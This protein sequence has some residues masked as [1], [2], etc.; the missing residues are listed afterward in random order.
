MKSRTAHRPTIA[1]NMRWLSLATTAA[2]LLAGRAEA[3]TL[4]I[5]CATGCAG[6]PGFVT[7]G[8]AS[9]VQTGA[10]LTVTQTTNTA[11]LNW[12]SFN[13]SADGTVTFV[14]PGASSI[15]L[16]KIFQADPAKI[17]GSLNANGQIYLISQNG[18]IFGSTAKVSV[19]GLLASTLNLAADIQSGLTAPAKNEQPALVPFTDAN[20][21]PL[22]SGAVAVQPGASIQTANAGSVLMFAPQITNEGTIQAPGGQV[23]LAAGSPVY[24]TSSDDPNIR[25][26]LVEVGS[27]GTV[28]N[29]NAGN[30]TITSPQ[31]LVGQIVAEH[32]NVT[33]AGLAVNQLGRVSATTTVN[34]NGSIRLQARTGTLAASSA[35]QGEAGGNLTLGPDSVTD[36]TLETSDPTTTVDSVP[37]AHSAVEMYGTNVQI[38]NNSRVTATSG[39]IAVQASANQSQAPGETLQPDGSRIY[40][41]PEATLD[42]SGATVELPASANVISAQLRG[43]EFA[44]FPLQRNG[45]LRG[46]TVYIDVRQ[47]GTRAD[48][49]TWQGTP[50]ADVSGEI[51][52]IQRN[53]A[54]RN[55]TGGTVSLQ[56][57]G[58]VILAPNATVNIAGGAINYDAGYINTT[59][60]VTAAGTLV[61]IANADPNQ[62]YTGIATTATVSHPKWG[63]TTTFPDAAGSP[64]TT[65]QPAYTEGKDAGTLNLTAAQFIFD[66]LLD[67][68]VTRGIYQRLPTV[69]GPLPA[70][71][72][73]RP[74][75]QVP[76]AGTL[77]IG[78]DFR[79]SGELQ[80]LLGDVSIDSQTVLPGL[81]AAGFDPTRDEPLPDSYSASILRP[82]LIG[83]QGIGNLQ[84]VS[85]G[86][87]TLPAS[88]RLSFSAD[89]SLAIDAESIDLLGS[90]DVSSGT[91][92][93]VAEQTLVAQNRNLTVSLPELTVGPGSELTARGAWVN[94]SVAL[95]LN[96]PTDPLLT[97]GGSVSLTASGGNLTVAA[98]SLI[99]VSGGAQLTSAGKL[100]P[101]SGGSITLAATPTV[102]LGTASPTTL[103]V[104][105]TLRAYAVGN[106]GTLSL[107]A[108]SVCIAQSDCTAGDRSVLWLTPDRFTAGGFA[109]YNISSSLGGIT[110]AP[111][112]TLDLYQQNLLAASNL[113]N[114]AGNANF[115][116]LATV[117]RLP[118]TV[119]KPSSL[120]LSANIFSA[121]TA[122]MTAA[123]V[124]QAPNLDIGAGATIAADARATVNLSS[125]T[126]LIVDGTIDAPAGAIGL[127]L[128]GSLAEIEF[129]PAQAIWLGSHGT[130]DAAGIAQIV[131]N[132]VGLRSGTVQSG[133]S[134]T[135][136]ANRGYF[137]MLPGSVM[138][139]AGAA[140]TIDT[141]AYVGG[142]FTT[143][144]TPVASAGGVIA[145][146][147]AEGMMLGGTFSAAP[148]AGA[149]RTPAGGS[150]AIALNGIGR[151]DPGTPDGLN[152]AF[153]TGPRTIDIEQTPTPIVVSP[154][155]AVPPAAS[156]EALVFADALNAAGFDTISLQAKSLPITTAGA[157]SLVP[158]EILFGQNATLHTGEEIE[159]D[160]ASV[161]VRPGATATL[162]APYVLMGNSDDGTGAP[163]PAATDGTGTLNVGTRQSNAEY[164]DLFGN[165]SLQGVGQANFYSSGDIRLRG[166][167]QD[168]SV[169]QVSAQSQCVTG[170]LAAGGNIALTAAQVYPDTLSQFAISSSATDGVID[171]EKSAGQ[172]GSVWSAG[173]TL[174]LSAA[175]I[176]QGGVLRAP[177]G[178]IVLE[179]PAGGA[180][181]LIDLAPGSLTSTSAAGMTI[182]FGTTEGGFDWTFPLS[183]GETVVYGTDGI[184][185]PAQHIAL[186]GANVTVASGATIDISGGGDLLAYEFVPG[187]GGTVDVLSAAARP[188]QYAIVPSLNSTVAPY[189]PNISSG[190]SLA[191]GASVYLAG[192]PGLP[193]GTYTLLPARYAM[194]PG[195]FLVTQVAGYTGIAPGLQYQNPGGGTVVAGYFTIAGTSIASSQ[196]SGFAVVPASV[197]SQ[198]AT[199]TTSVANQYFTDQ[200]KAAGTAATRLPMDSGVLAIIANTA[201]AQTNAQ[202]V[203]N[204]QLQGKPETGG[205]GAAV[206]ISS[207]SIEVVPDSSTTATPGALA[208]SATSLS[209]L[210]AQ[211]LLLGGQRSGAGSIETDAS[212]VVIASGASLSGPELLLAAT[213]NVTVSSGAVLTASGAAPLASKYKL[214]GDGTFLSV[215]ASPV[216]TVTR[217]NATAGTGVLDLQQGSQIN[218]AGGS[219]YLD[220]GNVLVNGSLGLSGGD[221]ALQSS[222]ISFGS[223]PAGTSG[224]L[225]GT[226]VLSAVALRGL[227]LFSRSTIDF[228]GSVTANT[229][230]LTLDSGGLVGHGGDSDVAALNVSGTLQ[231]SNLQGTLAS[232]VSGG[233]GALQLNA[234]D[235]KLASG[236]VPVS[237]F[238][239]VSLNAAGQISASAD[240]TMST[241]GDLT[242]SATRLTTQPAVT[243]GFTAAGKLA[244]TAPSSGATLSPVTDLGGQIQLTGQSVDIGTAIDLPAGKVSISSTGG[245]SG[246]DVVLDPGASINVAGMTRVYDG[247]NVAAPGGSISIGSAGNVLLARGSSVDLSGATGGAAGSLTIAATTGKVD[248]NGGLKGAGGGGKG[249]S[250]SVDAM[251]IG[252]ADSTSGFVA[253]NTAL[254]SDGFT[255]DRSVR[256]RGVGDLN[257]DTITGTSVQLVADQGNVSVAGPIDVSGSS[258]GSVLLAAS[259]DVTLSGNIDAHATGAGQTGGRVELMTSTGGVYFKPGAAINVAGGPADSSGEVG[260]GGTV[261]ARVPQDTVLAAAAASGGTGVVWQG[262]V[263]GAQTTTLEAFR[264]YNVDGA[265]SQSD[266]AV[267]QMFT[268]AQT[269]MSN[270]GTLL[271]NLRLPSGSSLV[272][273]PGIEIDDTDTSSPLTISSNWNLFNWRF[274]MAQDPNTGAIIPG[275]G[276][277]GILTLRAAAGIELD[278]A[279]LS[280]GFTLAS[281]TGLNAARAYTLPPTN[282]DSWSYRL[283]GGADTGSADVLAVNASAPAN[284]SL[285]NSTVRTGNGFIDVATSG[286]LVLGDQKSVI[287]TA[288][289]AGPGIPLTGN[290]L[291]G[292]LKGLAYP[293]DGGDIRITAAGDIVG[294][295]TNQFV[296]PWLW[297]VGGGSRNSAAAWTVSF[298]NFQQ[299]VAALGGGNVTVNAG[300]DITDLSVSAPSIGRQVGGTSLADS[301]VQVTGS[302]DV[303]V[304]AGGSIVGGSYYVGRG[305]GHLVA[306]NDIGGA[307]NPDGTVADLAPLLGVGDAQFTVQA[308]GNLALSGIVNPTLLPQGVSQGAGSTRSYFST[309][310]P[311][312][313][314]NLIAIGGNI[315]LSDNSQALED[316]LTGEFSGTLTT[317]QPLVF[318]I[319]PP[320]LTGAALDGDINLS[321]VLTLFPAP[322]GNLQLLAQNNING[323]KGAESNFAEL[324]LSDQDVTLLPSIQAPT[325]SLDP[326]ASLSNPFGTE[327]SSVA[328]AIGLHALVPV[329]SLAAQPDGQADSTPVRLVAATGDIL[330]NGDGTSESGLISAKPADV[331]AGRDIVNLGLVTQNL[332]SSDVTVVSAGRDIIYPLSRNGSGSIVP[333]LE[334]ITV[335]GPGA[336]ELAAGRNVNLG[337][338][339]GITT[340]G[341]LSNPALPAGGADVSI[342]AG[343]G[344]DPTSLAQFVTQYVDGSDLFDAPILS[345]IEDLTGST[346]LTTAQAKQ[347]FDQ[348]PQAQ[349]LQAIQAALAP[350][351]AQVVNTYI[352]GSSTYD[353]ALQAY[354]GKVTGQTGLSAAAAKQA[355]QSLSPQLQDL[356]VDQVIFAEITT[357][358]TKAVSS[359]SKDYTAA[360]AALTTLFPA[361]NPLDPADQST[362]YGD[363]ELYFS[364]VYTL[365]GGSISLLAPGGEINVGLAQPP[366]SFGIA[367]TPDQL[368]IVAEGV[369]DVNALAYKD[370]QVNESRVFAADGGNILVWSTDGD[371]DAGRG[372]KTAI[373]APPPTITV[374]ANGQLVVTVSPALTGSGIQALTTTPGKTAGTVSLFAPQGVVNANDAGIVAGN[375]V[376]GATAILG[377]NNITFS[378]TAIGLPPPTPALG[379]SLAGATS[380]AAGASSA[381]QTAFADA[382]RSSASKAPLA[383]SALS[384]IDVFIIGLGDESC[385]PEDAECLKRQQHVNP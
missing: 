96:G 164:I 49:S 45:P 61:D 67:G 219:A 278:N 85:S 39:T 6:I 50:L 306:G 271:G 305:T 54:E 371:I 279:A 270:A 34:E 31:Q 55:L 251:Q 13:I 328:G 124:A 370:F 122:P 75:D 130:L 109:R 269:F 201:N 369:G 315:T 127:T 241:S 64:T 148:G 295:P 292:S 185:P 170:A 163:P 351:Y 336:L 335:D 277:P 310:A 273:A 197:Y 133:G 187:T 120:A 173:G 215:S 12:Q 298:Q 189:D 19:G 153:P 322:K 162:L 289:V 323:T 103:D 82:D 23:L 384:W 211:S 377:A 220:G 79:P 253:L 27:G 263:T 214:N 262:T 324:V 152:S 246:S 347:A 350:H 29:G 117:T 92:S 233:T 179:G 86:K 237:G 167:V 212:S 302:G 313:V 314:A 359:G 329:H 356:F 268:D 119:R 358:G 99:D 166:V 62:I 346:T 288:G 375:L 176:H 181:S 382:S 18:I 318:N 89:G 17:F 60:L 143:V 325:A 40:V 101:G 94:D 171:I 378:G 259:G 296:T 196:T 66:G 287:Y 238:N 317:T 46:Q 331:V 353:T 348:L 357:Q 16:N 78:N 105:G 126:Q 267:Q 380:T 275:S 125:N 299:G 41:A 84:L 146:T 151:Q 260:T 22:T 154:G 297:R 1:Y 63:V 224:T 363:I 142:K 247:V 254:N 236:N 123:Q 87:V 343:I 188:N 157:Q 141:S 24:L 35:L 283:I 10:Q 229:Q 312:S 155:S 100:V 175:T 186:N 135:V 248:V 286:D 242:L 256:L 192:A 341:N 217:T 98:G 149:A 144:A 4:P 5:P 37:Q 165:Q 207:A 223:V 203:L 116:P 158:G 361:A 111:G 340:R 15:A 28:T 257:V 114:V 291:P 115:L 51:G 244:L 290:N 131:P 373:S 245:L 261:L 43:T 190:S 304:A 9:A 44:D 339:N 113:T 110:V 332:T 106:G 265:L 25:G 355:F 320:T 178:S 38:Q 199:Y 333:T 308:R 321:G 227:S 182:P 104:A 365:A 191:P 311:D 352:N 32:G 209:Q 330:F 2:T 225:L 281:G 33:L 132:N 294:A 58:D 293:T 239:A 108:D 383:E 91:L 344:V 81:M 118:D 194:L 319:L 83:Q 210:G 159:L 88:M 385:K 42:V 174:T 180:N 57:Q 80:S 208:L 129:A 136:T 20:N 231:L 140:G 172:P 107:T 169:C 204:G 376:V 74:Y 47:Y 72:L 161:G 249:G 228:Y 221:L 69:P 59:K 48:G 374:N 285:T 282:S 276:V 326:F 177:F 52:A 205:L 147:A 379:A 77:V 56:S 272:L 93:A 234:Q 252:D 97:D 112:T 337:V 327:P 216:G 36:V 8:A 102:S 168:S 354:V 134:I 250:F 11:T 342:T 202:L 364:R 121:S 184:A 345:F 3:A 138:D 300:G 274:N 53:V 235:V 334:D 90:I 360:F 137:E 372:A 65:F 230:S 7:S 73:Y 70:S 232:P 280:D 218:A 366:G 362:R 226:G 255:G 240:T 284:V 26:L 156:G 71:T 95:N 258:A 213:D 160:A 301:D 30:A 150:L 307:T 145:V 381:A 338:S 193:A 303:S 198:E 309:Y 222:Q 206:D 316:A 349:Q 195:A 68:Q 264:T 139:I 243:M 367:K 76:L 183:N 21:S 368:G 266:P 14:Q 128:G 200:A